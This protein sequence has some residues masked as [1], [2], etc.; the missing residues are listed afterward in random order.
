MATLREIATEQV[1]ILEP[2]HFIGRTPTSALKLDQVYI[3]AQHAL[4]RW[5]GARWELKDLG[6]RNGTFL[7]GVRVE[8]GEEHPVRRGSR[9]AFGK[10]E[11]QWEL[12]DESPPNVMVV[13]RDGGEPI[14]I[15]GELLALPS[16]E[17]PRI[18]IY[19]SDGGWVLERAEESITP[20]TNLQTFDVGNRVWRFCCP[21]S[22]WKTGLADGAAIGFEVRYLQ[23][24]F[25]VSSD[26][27]TVH[28]QM[29]CGGRVVDMGSRSHNYLLVTLARRRL[30]DVA[31]GLSDAACGWIY[32]EELGRD[33]EMCPPQLNIDVFR[34]RKQFAA[35]GVPDA[36]NII[37]RRPRT[38]QIRLGTSSVSVVRL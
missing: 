16:S 8:P 2:E 10:L 24:A 6:S 27:E 3:S 18:T 23:L 17:D 25:S 13:P 26:E 12:I 33:P 31:E 14:V 11:H 15:E 5:T 28:L 32:Q 29:T 19:R 21:D 30:D 38:R 22:I 4:L 35:A 37:E 1:Q 20:I 34:I 7:D 9:V 36:A